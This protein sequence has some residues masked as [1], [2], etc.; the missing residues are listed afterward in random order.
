MRIK[1]VEAIALAHY[2]CNKCKKEFHT[3]PSAVTCTCGSKYL[4]WLNFPECLEYKY[5]KEAHE[6]ERRDSTNAG[7]GSEPAVEEPQRQ[8]GN[9]EHSR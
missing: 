1:K 7:H 6:N 8:D 4:T 2:Q 5:E 9:T 3:K